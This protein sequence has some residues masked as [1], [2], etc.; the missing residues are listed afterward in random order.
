MSIKSIGKIMKGTLAE[1]SEDNV[2]RLSAALAYYS[3][4][5]IGP[6]LVIAVGLAGFAFGHET[7]RRQLDDQ[8]RGMIGTNSTQMIDSMMSAQKPGQ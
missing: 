1:F 8:L 7:V 5:S 2:M 6:L 3:M 4:F